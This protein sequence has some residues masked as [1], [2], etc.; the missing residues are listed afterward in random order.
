MALWFSTVIFVCS[1]LLAV[2]CQRLILIL[3]TVHAMFQ[4]FPVQ[5]QA[6][7]VVVVSLNRYESATPYEL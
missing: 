3:R 2:W 4:R 5:Y 6:Y 7:G 1:F